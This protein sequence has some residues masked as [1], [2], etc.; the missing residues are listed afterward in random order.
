MP[1]SSRISLAGLPSTSEGGAPRNLAVVAETWRNFLRSESKIH[2][3]P[4][5]CT[6]LGVRIGS[7]SQVSSARFSSSLLN[8][9]I[10]FC[11]VCL[12]S[13]CS[14]V[15]C[16]RELYDVCLLPGAILHPGAGFRYSFTYLLSLSFRQKNGPSVHLSEEPQAS[17]FPCRFRSLPIR[18]QR[19]SLTARISL[20][21]H[22]P[23]VPAS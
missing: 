16:F 5:G 20:S 7:D 13:T 9:V 4:R 12:P 21:Q 6:V 1:S 15:E 22:G 11:F 18:R 14:T 2:V 10:Y 19:H 23:P 3:R 17:G 8:S